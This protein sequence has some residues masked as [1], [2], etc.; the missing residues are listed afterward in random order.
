LHVPGTPE[1]RA[2]ALEAVHASGAQ[3]GSFASE[4]GRL[5]GLYRELVRG[6]P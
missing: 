2:Q 5:E 3:I 4:D 6:A 1:R